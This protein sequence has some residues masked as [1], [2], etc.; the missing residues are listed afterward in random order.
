MPFKEFTLDERTTITVYKRKASRSL[1]MSMTAEGKIRVSIPTWAPYS[2]GVKFARS[3]QAWIEAQQKPTALLVD[4]Q[5][6][7]RAHRLTI[8]SGE[9]RTVTT[10]V[11]GADI[12]ITMP[13]GVL[14]NSPAVQAAA[15]KACIRALRLE[16]ERLLPQ[17]LATLAGK[18]HFEYNSVKIK[19]LK[20]RWGSCDQSQNI[21]LNL[22][23]MQLPWDCID[24]VLLHEL[25][26]TRYLHHGKEFWDCMRTMITDL[27]AI[28]KTIRGYQPT[29]FGSASES[30]S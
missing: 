6:I 23:L 18:H 24:Y 7:G 13:H 19:Q 12:I 29:V 22:F 8:Q 25:T 26:H 14:P 5:H 20:S 16:A 2:A 1:R 28:R 9:R 11:K 15:Q 27:S 17:R 10:R 3:R 30:M 4:G 21:V